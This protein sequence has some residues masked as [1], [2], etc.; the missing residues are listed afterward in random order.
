MRMWREF[1]DTR[2]AASAGHLFGKQVISSEVWTWLHSPTFHATPLD[3]KA[4]ADLHFLQGINQLVGHGWPYS[5]PEAGEPG[6]RMYAAGAF[7]AHNPWSF[8]MPDLAGYLQRVS[9]AL[10]QGK[11]TNDVALLLP[12]DDAWASFRV[13]AKPRSVTN[14]GG[15]DESGSNVSIDESMPRLVG[16]KV[17]GSILDA[18]F[19]VDFIDADAIEKRGIPYPVLVLPAI[20]RI[21]AAAYRKI[22]EYARSGGIVVATRRIP[23]TVPG[24]PLDKAQAH[25]IA[26]ISTRLFRG[27]QPLAHLIQDEGDIGRAVTE[28]L[29]PDV[30]F[31]SVPGIFG[32]V[33][34][35]L[36]DADIYFIAN[37]TNLAQQQ[38]TVHFRAEHRRAELWDPFTGEVRSLKVAD[39]VDLNLEPYES[40][41]LVLTNSDP[42]VTAA[43]SLRSSGAQRVDLSHDWDVDFVGLPLKIH[44]ETLRSWSDDEQTRFYSGGVA[45][46]KD[47]MLNKADLVSAASVVIDFGKGTAVQIPDPLPEQNMRAYLE[48]PVRDA[49]EVYVNGSLAGVVWH[50]PYTLEIAKWLKP[51]R[52]HLRIVVANTAINELSGRALPDYRLLNDRFGLRFVPQGMENLRPLPSGML[53]GPQLIVNQPASGGTTQP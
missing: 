39:A 5:P 13:N 7:N 46:K 49:A 11:P 22:E 30:S 35:R 18:G 28:H 51:G 2:W 15:F 50:P 26:E 33:H 17:I 42:D 45:Y 24:M 4:E 36:A 9:F 19:N 14:A 40:R 10:R 21:P 52:N 48:G 32:F 38:T 27:E 37:T 20:D 31:A 47:V 29:K 25:S 34:R 43:R 1:S 44:M 53:A 8:A 41:L 12:T 3:M 16:K 6:W 23:A